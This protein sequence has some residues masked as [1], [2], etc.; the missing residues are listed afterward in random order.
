MSYDRR[1]F[2][3]SPMADE[4]HKGFIELQHAITTIDQV[5]QNNIPSGV[6]SA[7]RGLVK[8]LEASAAHLEKVETDLR[9]SEK[10]G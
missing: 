10:A 6:R 2:G 8:Q 4:L 1:A 5:E 7:L 9:I 3:P